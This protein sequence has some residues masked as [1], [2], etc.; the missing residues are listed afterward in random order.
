MKMKVNSLIQYF[1]INKLSTVEQTSEKIRRRTVK[2]T[3]IDYVKK[4]MNDVKKNNDKALLKYTS[5]FDRVKLLPNQLRVNNKEIKEA[6][7]IID[8]EIVKE[9]K[10]LKKSVEKTEKKIMKSFSNFVNDVEIRDKRSYIKYN[11]VP[12]ESVGCYVPGGKAVYPSSLVMSSIPAKIAGVKRIIVCSPPSLDKKIN[13]SVLVAAD[14]CQVDEIYKVGGAQAIAAM[15]YGTN[16]IKPVEKIVG[17]GNMFV[18]QAKKIISEDVGIDLPAGPSELLIIAD[19]SADK[20]LII[21]DLF[22]QAEH[23]TDSLCGVVTTSKRLAKDLIK[24]I[25]E[26]LPQIERRDIVSKSLL[27]NGFIVYCKSMKECIDFANDFASEHLEIMT[28]NQDSIAK[29]MTS[30]GV[31]LIGN[32]TPAAF[33]DYGLGTNHV[34]PTGGS[35]KFYSALSSID[36]TRRFFIA[37][38]TKE[39][40]K[41]NL[42]KIERLSNQEGLINHGESAKAR[43]VN[44]NVRSIS[45][46][47]N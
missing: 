29:E 47:N 14:I 26:R 2:S 20:E 27:K 11:M 5:K 7:S 12:L 41:N 17:P 13:P 37:K 16:A 15:G 25:Q 43:F 18:Y 32:Y 31:V 40:L 22:A 10:I 30:S 39:K 34:L 4:I 28:E 21:S 46:K 36:F 8:S 44:E 19:N 3:D 23:G 6:Y 24:L 35:G 1:E 33:S 38:T 42:E 9:L 45:K